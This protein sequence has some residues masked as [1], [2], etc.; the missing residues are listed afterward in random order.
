MPCED[1]AGTRLLEVTEDRRRSAWFL[2]ADLSRLV[3]ERFAVGG[4]GMDILAVA[5]SLGETSQPTTGDRPLPGRGAK[6]GEIVV[7]ALTGVT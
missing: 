1:I 5:T 2:E 7:A 3:V 6:S 4:A